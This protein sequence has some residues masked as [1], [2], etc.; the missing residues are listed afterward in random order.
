MLSV[1]QS[2]DKVGLYVLEKKEKEQ[3]KKKVCFFKTE[4]YFSFCRGPREA[5]RLLGVI[6]KRNKKY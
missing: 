6:L 3:Q 5:I 2:E 4:A 1:V